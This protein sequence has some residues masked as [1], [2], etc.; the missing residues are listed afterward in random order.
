VRNVRIE[1]LRQL[2]KDVAGCGLAKGMRVLH[3]T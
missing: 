1:I 2:G 3:P